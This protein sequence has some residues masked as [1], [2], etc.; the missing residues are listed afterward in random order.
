ML[1]NKTNNLQQIVKYSINNIIIS[2]TPIEIFK[3]E[4]K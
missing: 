4:I 1:R 2:L 3:Y